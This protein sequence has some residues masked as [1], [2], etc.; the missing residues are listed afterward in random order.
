[1]DEDKMQERDERVRVALTQALGIHWDEAQ[2]LRRE[3][4]EHD[5]KA[6]DIR[7]A[8]RA[9]HWWLLA[10]ILSGEDVESLCACELVDREL[11]LEVEP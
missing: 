7:R 11:Y 4:A 10:G 6:A 3:A 8:V 5:A 1:M 2:R 9:G